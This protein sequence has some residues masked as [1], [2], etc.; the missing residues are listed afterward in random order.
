MI[1]DTSQLGTGVPGMLGEKYYNKDHKQQHY[2]VDLS[3]FLV[4]LKEKE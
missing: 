3:G 2:T 4:I 1:S